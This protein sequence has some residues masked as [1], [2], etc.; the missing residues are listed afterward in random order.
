MTRSAETHRRKPG[1]PAGVMVGAAPVPAG[2]RRAGSARQDA[3]II[4]NAERAGTVEELPVWQQEFL[5]R[6]WWDMPGTDAEFRKINFAL[7]RRGLVKME[8]LRVEDELTGEVVSAMVLRTADSVAANGVGRWG[9]H[10]KKQA[11]AAAAKRKL[12]GRERE[13]PPPAVEKLTRQQRTA[14]RLENERRSRARNQERRS[15]AHLRLVARYA[16]LSASIN[17]LERPL[18]QA[19]RYAVE[20]G[21]WPH[22]LEHLLVGHGLAMRQDEEPA[23]TGVVEALEAWAG[24]RN[25]LRHEAAE[26]LKGMRLH[27]PYGVDLQHKIGVS[28]QVLRDLRAG[29][30]KLCGERL[31]LLVQVLRSLRQQQ[32]RR[33]A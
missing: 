11:L 15:E 6:H 25:A 29:E 24:E 30:I 31:D 27:G 16:A 32:E 12:E 19:R 7:L 4:R 18:Q 33:A 1:R 5:G 21:R 8:E 14:R 2:P 26:L 23:L 10:N 3:V 22:R 28:Q 20:R 9:L 17:R 13:A